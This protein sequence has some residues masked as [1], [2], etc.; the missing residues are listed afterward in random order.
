MADGLRVRKESW[1]QTF[2]ASRTLWCEFDPIGVGS[3][4]VQCAKLI[5]Q[6][7]RTSEQEGALERH[8]FVVR[9]I[10]IACAIIWPVVVVGAIIDQF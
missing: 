4:N 3:F 10:D 7:R 1:D 5:C 8:C 6:K 2:L 9:M